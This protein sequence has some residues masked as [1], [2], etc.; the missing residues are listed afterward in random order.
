MKKIALTALGLTGLLASCGPG[1]IVSPTP[2]RIT[3]LNSYTTDYYRERVENGQ[4]VRDYVICNDRTTNLYMDVSW[5]GPLTRLEARLTY[6]PTAGASTSRV[7]STNTFSPD[8]SG[9]DIF[10]YTLEANTVTGAGALSATRSS[11]LSAQAIKAQAIVVNP[12]N[13]GTLA[14]DLWGYNANGV[15][16]N[17][18]QAPG[19]LPVLAT[20]G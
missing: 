3:T 15:K 8:I 20:C 13:M 7:V 16:S 12:A 9:R 11:N 1:M 18:L 17:E 14:V 19:T 6:T 2:V 4:V 10:T 5:T